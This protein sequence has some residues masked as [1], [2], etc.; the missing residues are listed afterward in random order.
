MT[1]FSLPVLTLGALL[2]TACGDVQTASVA[3]LPVAASTQALPTESQTVTGADRAFGNLSEQI[4]Y[5]T[6]TS[7][8]TRP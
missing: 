8:S 7:V 1:R 5:G 6:V 2:F 3:D 4:V